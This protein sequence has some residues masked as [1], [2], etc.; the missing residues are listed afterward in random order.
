MNQFEEI[1]IPFTPNPATA[2]RYAAEAQQMYETAIVHLALR[3]AEDH[4]QERIA[5]LVASQDPHQALLEL[6]RMMRDIRWSASLE[7]VTAAIYNDIE[8]ALLPQKYERRKETAYD[9]VY[10]EGCSLEEKAFRLYALLNRV[11]QEI[12]E[13][14]K[15]HGAESSDTRSRRRQDVMRRLGIDDPYDLSFLE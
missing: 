13:E 15:E 1:M 7:T 2:R 11:Q 12:V 6:I 4:I 9:I 14:G 3:D 10:R 8:V 5:R